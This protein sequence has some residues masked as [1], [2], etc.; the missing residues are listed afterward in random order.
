MIYLIFYY[1]ALASSSFFLAI[2]QFLYLYAF[3][4]VCLYY[5]ISILLIADFWRFIYIFLGFYDPSLNDDIFFINF[6]LL[7]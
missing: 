6:S 4:F 1:F 5:Y 3:V 7:R 2:S